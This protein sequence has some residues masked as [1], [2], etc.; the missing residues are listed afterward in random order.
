MI[1]FPLLKR[2]TT[3]IKN[4]KKQRRRNKNIKKQKVG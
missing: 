1:T 2:Q 3:K 4:I